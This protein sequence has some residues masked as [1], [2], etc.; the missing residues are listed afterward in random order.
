M[1]LRTNLRPLAKDIAKIVCELA[2][3][4][5]LT[6]GDYVLSGTYNDR[7]GHVSLTVTTNRP[8]DERLWNREITSK[9]CEKLG[10]EFSMNSGLVVRSSPNLD[11]A[12][13][14]DPSGLNEL[15]LTDYLSPM[16]HPLP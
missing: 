9:M 5:G 10:P 4:T 2:H 6:F 12:F 15:D 1:A 16:D 11:E 13:W 8:V 3:R 7:N 14:A